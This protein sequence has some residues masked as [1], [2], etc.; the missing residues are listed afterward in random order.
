M[1][2]YTTSNL[3]TAQAKLIAAFVNSE[4]R[5]R[6]PRVFKL[7]LQ[8]SSIML[9]DYAQLRTREDRAITAYFK[10][11]ASRSLGTGRSHNH[12]G[13]RGDSGSLTPSWTTYKDVYSHSLKQA[14]RNVFSL[15]EM[16]ANDLQN[17][18]INH[19]E[20]HE[21][22]AA[23][24]LFAQ[25][26]EVNG[27]TV[28]GNFNTVTD[29]FEIPDDGTSLGFGAFN[30]RAAQ[31]T[32]VVMEINKWGGAYT[33]VCDTV[34][35]DKFKAQMAQGAANMLNLSFNFG[36]VEF[37][38]SVDLYAMS[39]GLGYTDGYWIVVP[40]GTIACL[41]HI[42]KE[43]REGVDTKMQ[44][45]GSIINPIDGNTYA[46]HEYATVGDTS[47]TGGYTQDEV[48]Q[49]E[50]TIDL[51]FEKAPLSVSLESP[52]QAFAISGT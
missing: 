32:N 11:R 21:A 45:Y 20:G 16:M 27:A 40:T 9:P 52:L 46:I 31:I 49:I 1:A 48:T 18:L 28:E 6:E 12:T 2:Y 44:N 3:L 50:T 36:G 13:N 5:F 51:A 47:A 10:L 15:I 22:T 37:I 42:P 29:T 25:R 4:M 7:F 19:I 39:S 30:I 14:N 17:S 33:V 26:S 8:N 35:F 43:N 23:A 24:Y 34:A 41:P 38:H